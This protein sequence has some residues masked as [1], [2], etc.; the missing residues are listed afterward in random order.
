ARTDWRR[1]AIREALTLVGARR[2]FQ[3]WAPTNP[4][5]QLAF[6][7]VY[8]CSRFLRD[9]T[10][11]AGV[12]VIHGQV[13]PSPVDVHAFDGKPRGEDEPP[14]RWLWAGR[15]SPDKGAATALEALALL[16]DEFRGHLDIYG[17][18]ED[19]YVDGLRAFTREHALPVSF[20]AAEPA[21]M[22][23]VY[24]A[25]DA[26]LF[27][28]QWDEPFART[29]LEAMASGL[30]VIATTTGGSPELFRDRDNALTYTAGN[31]HELADRVR[32]LTR[33]G[34]LRARI[35]ATGRAE[36]HTTYAT[37]AIVD[38]I[39]D[40]LRETLRVWRPRAVPPYSA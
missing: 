32:E 12:E 8:F 7:R 26:L 3:R 13:I 34:A 4:V 22:P 29:P 16:R 36:V 1:L 37:D 19:A 17:A 28:S 25:H 21:E 10:A 9:S 15:L 20:R 11:R 35:A 5:R 24:R 31:P 39:E 6:R 18:G 23:A 14:A 33:N 27:T 30:P 38:R 2:L 40:D